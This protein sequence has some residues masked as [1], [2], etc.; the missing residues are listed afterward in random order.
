LR[1]R[2]TLASQAV[3]CLRILAERETRYGGINLRIFSILSLSFVLQQRFTPS[4]LR[5]LA[6]SAE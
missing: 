2:N 6:Y 5:I 3:S 4:G 1:H